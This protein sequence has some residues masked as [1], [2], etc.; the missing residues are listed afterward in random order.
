MRKNNELPIDVTYDYPWN[1]YVENEHDPM[2]GIWTQV[3]APDADTARHEANAHYGEPYAV[4]DVRRWI[5][6]VA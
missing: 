3:F 1:V 6:A 5:G 2:D 4:R